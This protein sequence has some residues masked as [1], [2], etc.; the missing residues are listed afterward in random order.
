MGTAVKRTP[1]GTAAWG[2]E[3]GKI[4]G[5]SCLHAVKTTINKAS[6]TGKTGKTGTMCAS[7]RPISMSS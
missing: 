2:D 1:V 4:A 6:K 3:D 7:R 5:L